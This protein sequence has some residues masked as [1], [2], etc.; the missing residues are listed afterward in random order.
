MGPGKA[1]QATAAPHISSAPWGQY[2]CLEK[3][4]TSR[5]AGTP[6]LG[7]TPRGSPSLQLLPPPANQ[8]Q[9]GSV[10]PSDRHPARGRAGNSSNKPAHWAWTT[11]GPPGS[12]SRSQCGSERPAHRAD[13]G[14]AQLHPHASSAGEVRKRRDGRGRGTRIPPPSGSR[15]LAPHAPSDPTPCHPTDIPT[16]LRE[17]LSPPPLKPSPTSCG[18]GRPLASI[19]THASTSSPWPWPRRVISEQPEGFKRQSSLTCDQK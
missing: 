18:R 9:P 7:V 15:L 2:P 4:C 1:P 12:A 17:V 13:S 14:D 16:K 19:S 11:W 3:L 10:L 5:N 8:G 6:V